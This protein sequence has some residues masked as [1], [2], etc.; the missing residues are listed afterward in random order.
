VRRQ[1]CCRLLGR[2]APKVR[3]RR[4]AMLA[5]PAIPLPLPG[6]RNSL[7]DLPDRGSPQKPRGNARQNGFP[8]DNACSRHNAP[9][10]GRG[11][12]PERPAKGRIAAR[13]Q[14][15]VPSKRLRSLTTNRAATGRRAGTEV[16]GCAEGVPARWPLRGKGLPTVGAEILYPQIGDGSIANSGCQVSLRAPGTAGPHRVPLIV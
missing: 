4:P 13:P 7:Q 1:F 3:G 15:H 8:G 14:K 5:G 11:P 2:V 9:G 6:G 16:L 10:C 12:Q